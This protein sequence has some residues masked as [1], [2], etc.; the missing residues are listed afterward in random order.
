MAGPVII[1]GVWAIQVLR[2][3]EGKKFSVR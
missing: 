2:K 1:I 3:R